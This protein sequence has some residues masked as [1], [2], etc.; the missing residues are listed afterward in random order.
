M[1]SDKSYSLEARIADMMA[2]GIL[3]PLTALK[4]GDTHRTNTTIT[5]DPDLSIALE[6]SSWYEFRAYLNYEGGPQGSSDIKW[7]FSV[8][9][10]AGM[11]YQRTL[12]DTSGSPSVGITQL[13]AD[14]VSARTNGAGNLLAVTMEG[15]IKTD[16]TAGPVTFRFAQNTLH[17]TDVILHSHSRMSARKIQ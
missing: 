14:N 7:T 12:V 16:V 9:A 13:G 6:A 15:T 3:A 5:D 4:T 1:T 11:R 10:A 2:R 8:P 17:A